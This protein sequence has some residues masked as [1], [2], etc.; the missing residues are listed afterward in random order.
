MAADDRLYPKPVDPNSSFVRVLQ[1]GA[2][3]AVV[4]GKTMNNLVN[5]I[6]PYVNVQPGNIA[7]SA[8]T[9]S[10]TFKVAPGAYYT[11]AWTTSGEGIAMKDVAPTDASKA[12][13]Y[14]YNL[15]DKPTIDLFVPSAKVD[16]VSDV[17][18]NGSKG[19]ALK[20]PLTLNVEVHLRDQHASARRSM[21]S[22]CERKGAVSVVLTGSGSTYSA[23]ALPNAFYVSQ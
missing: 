11:Y 10:A 21:G 4:D 13:V 5:G 7:V 3:V 17:P 22:T 20:A 14:V 1:P 18:M 9:S 23:V 16:A 19:V 12:E 15:S 2:T 8:G 6:S